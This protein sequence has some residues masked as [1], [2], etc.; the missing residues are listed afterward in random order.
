[1]P[2]LRQDIEIPATGATLRGWLYLPSDVTRPSPAVVMSHGFSAVKEMFLAEYAEV[3]AGAGLAVIVYDQRGF[4]ASDGSPRQEIDPVQQMR[5]V[6]DVITWASTRPEV[7]A[8]RIGL[9]GSSYSGGHALQV[10]AV[11]KRV[12]CVVAQVPLVSGWRSIQRLVRGDMVAGLRAMCDGDRASRFAGNAPA[13]IPVVS[14]DPL[15]P[16]A[17]P[18]MD[19]WAWFSRV[20][21]ER[22]PNWRNEITLRSFEM[23]C[24][25]EPGLLI[26][27]ISPTPMLMIVARDDHLTPADIAL[28][29][30]ER[31]LE[32][33]QLV[34]VP[35]GHFDAY[36]PAFAAT[37]GAARDWFARHL[38]G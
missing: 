24:E 7:D 3:F 4:G 32:P 34:L 27:R 16:C 38:I 17:L 13:M 36:G 31:A 28:Q 9:W 11:D 8:R 21:A 35:G 10:A 5:D 30:Y 1:M 22:A 20:A 6:R 23:A 18:P 2:A 19:G 33:K 26:E 14:N 15:Q 29:A 25:Y 37:S 12:R